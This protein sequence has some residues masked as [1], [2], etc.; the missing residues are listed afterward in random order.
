MR[1][2]CT[3]VISARR[4]ACCRLPSLHDRG[5]E[6]ILRERVLLQANGGSGVHK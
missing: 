3:A 5:M 4:D 1:K 2:P 6:G